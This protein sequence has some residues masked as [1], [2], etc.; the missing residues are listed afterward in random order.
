MLKGLINLFK[1]APPGDGWVAYGQ[2]Q[3]LRLLVV[4]GLVLVGTLVA[5]FLGWL[6]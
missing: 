6:R 4:L 3:R 1:P 2:R 5:S